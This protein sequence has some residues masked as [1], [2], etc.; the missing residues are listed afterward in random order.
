MSLHL[1]P[2]SNSVDSSDNEDD[3]QSSDEEN[4]EEETWDDW[5]SDSHTVGCKSLFDV[6]VLKSAEDALVYD[7]KTHGFDL[8]EACTKLCSYSTPIMCPK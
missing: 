1:P 7:K 5:I 3:S 2:P 6:K 4:E 8:N